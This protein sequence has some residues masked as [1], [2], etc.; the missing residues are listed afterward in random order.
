MNIKTNIA[1]SKNFGRVRN[2]IKYIVVHYTANDGDTDEAN[3]NYFKNNVVKT[4]AHWFIDDESA[5]L[6]VPEN[7]AAYSVG[8]AKYK[9]TNGGTFYGKCTNANS[10]NFELCDTHRNGKSDFS[11]ETL[12]NAVELIKEKMKQY[13][14]TID[15]VIRHY[16]VTG[17]ICPKPFVE[18]EQAWRN[19]KNRLISNEQ[20]SQPE[21]KPREKKIDD[22]IFDA[23]LYYS[24]YPDLQKAFGNDYE[25][26]IEHWLNYGINE[27]RRGSYVFDVHSY[28]ARYE[29][30]R[31][32]IGANCKELYNHF[33]NCGIQEGRKSSEEF[34]L[35]YYKES[36]DDL[37]KAYGND[38]KKYIE[39]F[40]TFGMSEGRKASSAFYIQNYKNNY[41][42]LRKAFGNNLKLYYKHY[43]IFG[44]NEGR[45]G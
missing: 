43:I 36:Y 16:D 19:F 28:F 3:A 39:H 41:E 18:D 10:L 45:K 26:L 24:L 9:N 11:E 38:N 42:D 30:L 5:T 6:S 1:N 23:D 14:V 40:I 4:S 44:K 29:D 13:N 37:K 35:N 25:K 2:T 21:K 8:G 27:G 7:R 15:R 17:K 33:I 31:R 32:V 22:L 34:E 20:N 12:N